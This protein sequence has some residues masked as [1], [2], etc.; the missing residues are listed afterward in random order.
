MSEA[1]AAFVP[2]GPGDL[3]PLLEMMRE[4]YLHDGT[5]PFDAAWHRASLAPL[6]ADGSL[7]RVWVARAGG[8]P[9]GY[10]VVTFGYSLEFGGRDAFV[11]ELY[12]REGFRGAGLGRAAIATAMEACREAGVRALHLEVERTN[13]AAQ[14]FYRRLGFHDHDRYLLTRWIGPEDAGASG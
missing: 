3:E 2:A 7:G 13:V 14:G 1:A 5:T 4:L 12:L 6:L 8:E 9:A 10:L 11:D